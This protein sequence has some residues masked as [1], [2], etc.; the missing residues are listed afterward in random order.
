M[1]ADPDFL[2]PALWTA[3]PEQVQQELLRQA[4]MR[5][6]STLALA[7]GAD[8]RSVTTMGV[9]GA[10]AVAL[11]AAAI[12]LFASN[13]ADWL[14][15]CAFTIPALG[16]FFGVCMCLKAMAPVDFLPPGA[17][18]SSLFQTD[19]SDY[20]RFRIALIHLAEFSIKTN[21]ETIRRSSRLFNRSIYVALGGILADAVVILVWL[22]VRHPF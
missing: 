16:L 19:V 17:R 3:V 9:F 8:Q 1:S 7:Q 12:T 4:E 11:L 21:T 14:L 18:P 15:P 22:G 20:Q 5:V 13:R 6:R 2:D 10:V